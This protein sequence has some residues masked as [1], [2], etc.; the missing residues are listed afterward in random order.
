MSAKASRG[1]YL[2]YSVAWKNVWTSVFISIHG[3]AKFAVFFS[4]TFTVPVRFAF[5]DL[6]CPGESHFSLRG[7]TGPYPGQAFPEAEHRLHSGRVKSQT[8]LRR[9]HSQ[10]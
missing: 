1:L 3:P 7:C 8:K 2:Q 5:R 6:T 4:I 9:R 10:Q